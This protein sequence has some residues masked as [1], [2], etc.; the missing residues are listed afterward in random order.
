[1]ESNKDDDLEMLLKSL[2]SEDEY[3][4]REESQADLDM[5]E[6]D[7]CETPEF[8]ESDDVADL[9]DIIGSDHDTEEDD[10]ISRLD[11]IFND[12]EAEVEESKSMKESV[13]NDILSEG[14]FDISNLQIDDEFK[15]LLGINDENTMVL[16]EETAG[17]SED[18][19][20]RIANIEAELSTPE[21]EQDN[22][23]FELEA[24]N[25]EL[26]DFLSMFSDE[27]DEN[28][29]ASEIAITSN[30]NINDDNKKNNKIKAPKESFVNKLLSVF[31]KKDKKKSE[32]DKVNE[33]QQV[34]DELFDE[35]GE[36]LGDNKKATKKGLF[37]K[38][39][40]KTDSDVKIVTDTSEDMDSYD[41]F[42]GIASLDETAE[43]SKKVKKKK[44][45][46]KKE[47]PKKEKVKKVKKPKKEKAEKVKKPVE[48]HE[49]MKVKPGVVLL[50]L[51]LV[52]IFSGIPY[53]FIQFFTYNQA[54]D[55]ATYYLVDKKY[56]FAYESIVGISPKSDEDKALIEQIETIML[57]QKQYNSYER[58]LKMNRH[59][60][61]LD[62]LIKGISK[63]D[64]YISKAVEIGVGEDMENVKSL[65]VEKL[66]IEY[67]LTED[68]ARSYSLLTDPEQ[69]NYILETY[70][71][72]IDDSNN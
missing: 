60:D 62:S 55:S 69:Y 25:E 10:L 1:M 49:L 34:L 43:S 32:T 2:V 3:S 66:W 27:G 21:V 12:T 20:I 42:S 53:L 36:L 45:K 5:Q 50:I 15:D 35:N 16:P 23:S 14:S 39:S 31:K 33:N 61:A 65:I 40:K 72:R 48:P 11:G 59:I 56:T 22:N 37:S 18:D 67:G 28:V 46:V 57:V 38:V 6:P 4:I 47:K 52:V 64:T 63:Y 44:E 26:K 17:L 13:E 70:G 54:F 51:I 71:G 29:A 68:M 41:D 24:E 7:T 30:E 19:L 9:M 58:Y 8:L